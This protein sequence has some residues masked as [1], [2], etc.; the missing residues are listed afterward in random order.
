M[1]TQ[2]ADVL[3]IAAIDG[4][5][6][7]SQLQAAAD[8]KIPVIAYDRLIRDSK[9]VDFYASFD[10][11]KVG[12]AAGQRAAGGPRPAE[13]GRPRGRYAPGTVQRRAVR[14]LAGR[15]Q[16]ALLLQRRDGHA[17]AVPR[18]TARWS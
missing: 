7:S 2:G 16:R 1:I 11:Y 10:N 17:Q 6:L 9:N 8:A 5:A 3:I 4:T 18:Q 13:Q 12:V 15:Q 14:R